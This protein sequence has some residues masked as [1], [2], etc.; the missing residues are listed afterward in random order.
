ML[1]TNG[2]V[3]LLKFTIIFNIIRKSSKTI[4]VCLAY[5]SNT[6]LDVLTLHTE[7][8]NLILLILLVELFK[9]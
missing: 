2:F 6:S 4:T 8:M 9:A 5:N 7:I 1:N 3:L